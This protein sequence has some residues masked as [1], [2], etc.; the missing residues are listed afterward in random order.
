[1]SELHQL[2]QAWGAALGV[3]EF[4]GWKPE[5]LQS[6]ITPREAWEWASGVPANRTS[7]P[8]YK[9]PQGS[10]RGRLERMAV[11]VANALRERLHNAEENEFWKRGAGHE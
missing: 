2:R 4:F 7:R 6:G 1:M 11:E 3:C 10:E 5:E 8:I 9:Q